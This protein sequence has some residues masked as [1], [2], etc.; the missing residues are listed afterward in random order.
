MQNNPVCTDSIDSIGHEIKAINHILQRKMLSA[1]SKAGVDK[2]T[3][4]HGWIIGYLYEHRNTDVFQKDLESAFEISRSTV[5]S[6]LQLMERKGYI[7]RLSV[8]S[9]ARLKKIIL[10]PIGLDINNII[11]NTIM[12]HEKSFEDI[13]DDEERKT[14]LHLIRKLRL[15]LQNS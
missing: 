4:M 1:A 12:E 7:E 11:R 13:L 6:I 10:T 2:V 5:T 9:D 14:F 15:G 3:L 8:Q